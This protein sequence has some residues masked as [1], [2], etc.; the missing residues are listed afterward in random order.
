[1]SDSPLWIYKQP[2][3]PLNAKE[4][5][6][7]AMAVAMGI[8]RAIP[9]NPVSKGQFYHCEKVCGCENCERFWREIMDGA[10]SDLAKE[11]DRLMSKEMKRE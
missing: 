11:V 4:R 8:K 2:H 5:A 6:H 7:Y 3:C 9:C 1:M 10:A